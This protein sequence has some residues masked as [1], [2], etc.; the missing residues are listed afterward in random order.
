MPMEGVGKLDGTNQI[1]LTVETK[2]AVSILPNFL[3]IP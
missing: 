2:I 1:I 3:S